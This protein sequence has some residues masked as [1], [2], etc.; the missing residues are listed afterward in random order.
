MTMYYR[1]TK[2]VNASRNLMARVFESAFQLCE[3]RGID[4]FNFEDEKFSI[5]GKTLQEFTREFNKE[6]Q[7]V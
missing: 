4:Y 6:R 3:Q 7:Q 2:W 5:A 1:T